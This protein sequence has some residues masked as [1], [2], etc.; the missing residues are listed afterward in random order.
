[1]RDLFSD[2]L[3]AEPILKYFFL[4][5]KWLILLSFF[6]IGGVLTM[7]FA[8]FLSGNS[9]THSPGNYHPNWNRL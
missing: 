7:L 2:S 1:M 6:L 8:S 4:L 5:V 3:D 9:S